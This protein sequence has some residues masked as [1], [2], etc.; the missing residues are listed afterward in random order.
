VTYLMIYFVVNSA[1]T[2]SLK[3]QHGLLYTC[4]S[5]GFINCYNLTTNELLRTF[6]GNKGVCNS[7]VLDELFLYSAGDDKLIKKWSLAS[8]KLEK[9]FK[10]SL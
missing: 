7:I 6:E 10:G 5:D 9:S 2:L 4:R 1:S 8:G 3:A